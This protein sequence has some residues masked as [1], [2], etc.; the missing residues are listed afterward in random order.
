MTM[1]ITIHPDRRIASHRDVRAT[2]FAPDGFFAAAGF[3][4]AVVFFTPVGFFAPAGFF[5]AA[6]FFAP[7]G[8]FAGDAG[9]VAAVVAGAL[10]GA[11]GAIAFH[12]EQ[13]CAV[14]RVDDDDDE[15]ED[16]EDE[17]EDVECGT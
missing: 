8:F 16:D 7:D 9:V 14:R 12:V 13:N 17:D 4:V 6:G 10:E 11:F 2:F 15:D 1:T 5:A 3:F